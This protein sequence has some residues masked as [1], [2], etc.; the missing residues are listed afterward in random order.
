M[1]VFVRIE[2]PESAKTP[3]VAEPNRFRAP[4]FICP[5]LSK[6]VL[7]KL[8][9]PLVLIPVLKFGLVPENVAPFE[10]VAFEATFKKSHVIVEAAGFMIDPA[11]RKS[12]KACPPLIEETVSFCVS[13]VI[14]LSKTSIVVEKRVVS[15]TTVRPSATIEEK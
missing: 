7:L 2:P 1:A 13:L 12:K 9:A 4:A 10:K 11:V 3:T 8:F 14:V 6:F 15:F 5:Q